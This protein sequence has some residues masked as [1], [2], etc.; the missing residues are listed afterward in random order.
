[1]TASD[2]N[3]KKL[4][5]LQRLRKPAPA[6]QK[7]STYVTKFIRKEV[8]PRQKKLSRLGQAWQQL[9]PPELVEHSYLDSFSRGR[10]RVLVDT[11][12]HM[13]ELDLLLREGLLEHLQQL[14]PSVSIRQI[15]LAR[16]QW[17]D[18][19]TKCRPTRDR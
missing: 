19:A 5:A 17:I 14:C 4:V 10:L 7:L 3:L 16:G 2:W 13:G 18:P 1:M 6:A 8:T 15:K 11:A 12:G 9:L